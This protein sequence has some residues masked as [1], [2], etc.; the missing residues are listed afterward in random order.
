[1]TDTIDK[2]IRENLELCEKA[3]EGPWDYYNREPSDD[4]VCVYFEFFGS[5]TKLGINPFMI[6]DRNKIGTQV[7]DAQFITNSRTALPKALK[8]LEKAYECLHYYKKTAALT[9]SPAALCL[10]EIEELLSR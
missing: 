10:S 1:M 3:T 8:A 7:E 9:D 5:T 2:F 4:G 6:I